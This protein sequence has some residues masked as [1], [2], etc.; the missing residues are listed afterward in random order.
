MGCSIRTQT[1]VNVTFICDMSSTHALEI[2]ASTFEDAVKQ[3]K[4]DKN[5]HI[6]QNSFPARESSH[7]QAVFCP[8]CYEKKMEQL[9]NSNDLQ[10][11]LRG[12]KKFQPDEFKRL[13]LIEFGIQKHPRAD[14]AFNIAWE[15][16]SGNYLEVLSEL[17]ELAELLR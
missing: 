10:D 2:M 14:K 1:T 13:S 5:W 12:G 9:R 4:E 17:K 3:A 15:K 8:Q 7:I 11:Q 6:D 16:G